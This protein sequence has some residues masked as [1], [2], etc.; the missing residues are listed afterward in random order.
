MAITYSRKGGL[1]TTHCALIDFLDQLRDKMD[2]KHIEMIEKELELGGT[3]LKH[4]TSE[5]DTVQMD[6]L[7]NYFTNIDKFLGKIWK[8]MEPERRPMFLLTTTSNVSKRL[9]EKKDKMEL[10]YSSVVAAELKI[11]NNYIDT[12]GIDNDQRAAEHLR[13]VV[14]NADL[15]ISK[16]LDPQVDIKPKK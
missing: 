9:E 10:K 2:P 3:I 13:S 15:Y 4:I 14:L 11:V 12:N 6:H 7:S 8:D 1:V 5:D 16:A